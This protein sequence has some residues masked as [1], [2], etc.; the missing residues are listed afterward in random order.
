MA[1][2]IGSFEIEIGFGHWGI[3]SSLSMQAG[4]W[5]IY[6]SRFHREFVICRGMKTLWSYWR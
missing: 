2:S 6:W 1:L 4:R 3:P 5:D